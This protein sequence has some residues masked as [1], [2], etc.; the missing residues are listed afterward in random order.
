[1]CDGINRALKAPRWNIKRKRNEFDN[2]KIKNKENDTGN[3]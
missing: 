2:E 1:M 3:T